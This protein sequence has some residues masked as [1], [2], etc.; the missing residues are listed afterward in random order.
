MPKIVVSDNGERSFNLRAC[1][2]F[3]HSITESHQDVVKENT[4]ILSM[5][6]LSFSEK[7][8]NVYNIVLILDDRKQFANHSSRSRRLI[9][10]IC[11]QFKIQIEIR[12]LPFGDRIARHKHLNNEYVFLYLNTFNLLS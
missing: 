4:N 8:E 6:P 12:R 7:Y 1:S 10:N 9:E 2:S 11:S 3:N 5:T